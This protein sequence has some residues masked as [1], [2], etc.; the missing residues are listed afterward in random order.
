MPLLFQLF[1]NKRVEIEKAEVTQA[2]KDVTERIGKLKDA[3]ESA[4]DVTPESKALVGEM[5]RIEAQYGPVARAITEAA[6][7]GRHSEAVDMMNT[8]CRPLLAQLVKATNAYTA[9]TRE[10]GRQMADKAHEQCV[11]QRIMMFGIAP[12]PLRQRYLPLS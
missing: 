1:T 3:I 10:R 9:D 7:A 5:I 11:A 6:L 4:A 2:D 12:R 8:Q